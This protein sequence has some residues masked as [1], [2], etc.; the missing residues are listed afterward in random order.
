[1]S[2]SDPKSPRLRSD[3]WFNDMS[4]PGETAI[5]LER[6][7]NFGITRK[8]LQSHRPVI[9]IAQTGSD[10]APCNRVHMTLAARVKGRIQHHCRQRNVPIDFSRKLA[11][12]SIGD[13][14]RTQ[15]EKSVDS[16]QMNQFQIASAIRVLS[17]PSRSFPP[18]RHPCRN[19]G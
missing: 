2:E 12:R 15:V 17:P 8:E 3:I 10:I 4:E 16:S 7:N 1:M 19:V 14:T 5:Y 9:G 13:P 11:V 18:F 6:F